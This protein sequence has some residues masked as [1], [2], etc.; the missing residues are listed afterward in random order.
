MKRKLKNLSMLFCCLSLI[1]MSCGKRNYFPDPDDPGLSRLTSRGYNIITMYINNVPYINPY[2]R[3]LFGGVSNTLPA[4]TRKITNSDFDTLQISWQIEIND[5]SASYNQPYHSVSLLIPV[6]KSFTS[7]DF[8]SMNGERFSPGANAIAVNYP[9]NYSDSLAGKS[10][11][12]F[13]D[14]KYN[15]LG[16]G[17]RHSYSFSGLFDGNIGDSILITKGRFDFEIDADKI[18][19]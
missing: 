15:T 4:I 14:I 13:I 2:R 11:L 9:Y 8:L 16:D 18:N 17:S 6:S 19:F 3:P 5:T 10:N 12:Y 7:H 1:I